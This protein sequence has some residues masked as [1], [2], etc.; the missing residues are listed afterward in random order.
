MLCELM[1]RR[2]FLFFIF[3]MRIGEKKSLNRENK[4]Y[5]ISG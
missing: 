5:K 3:L 4:I 2:R 1:E